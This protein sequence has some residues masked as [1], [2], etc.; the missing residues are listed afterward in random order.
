MVFRKDVSAGTNVP[1]TGSRFNSP[2]TGGTG[3]RGAAPRRAE[4][5]AF[6]ISF[7]AVKIIPITMR[8]NVIEEETDDDVQYR[9]E[10][11]LKLCPKHEKAPPLSAES[12]TSPRRIY[13]F[14]AGA[15]LAGAG[16]FAPGA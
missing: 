16:F 2:V 8:R 7:I 1:H 4:R 15:V 10:H 12:A 3:G 5:S 9:S 14:F 13:F 6:I 11:S